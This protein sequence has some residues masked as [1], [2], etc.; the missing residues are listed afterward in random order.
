M[1]WNLLQQL[2]RKHVDIAALDPQRDA[3]IFAERLL[4]IRP[5]VFERMPSP[6]L[7]ALALARE[8]LPQIASV[9][10]LAR[11]LE[12]SIS[13]PQA[14]LGTRLAQLVALAYLACEQDLI[15][16]N[17][18]GGAG[19]VDDCIVLHGA[20]LVP[21]LDYGHIGQPLLDAMVP[22]HRLSLA[23]PP[24]VLPKLERL[25]RQIASLAVHADTLPGTVVE[26]AIRALVENPPTELDGPLPF[27][28]PPSH[29]ILP[30]AVEDALVL[31]LGQLLAGE[32]GEGLK[33]ELA[34]GRVFG[35]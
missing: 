21:L 3:T 32:P 13:S 27:T 29:S 14:S 31:P 26:D 6:P 34:D 1:R 12:A 8:L 24:D 30:R 16:D 20:R 5:E 25:L 7:A 9:P 33:V 15:R 10:E 11:G 17:L 23:V 35:G 19:L 2:M 28:L 18:P 22:V 4:D